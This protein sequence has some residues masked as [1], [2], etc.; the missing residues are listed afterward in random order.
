LVLKHLPKDEVGCCSLGAAE[1]Q[2]SAL[3]RCTVTS[4]NILE[5]TM[6]IA[7]YHWKVKE[8][9]EKNFLEGW[10]RRTEEIYQHCGSL[11]SRLHQAEDGTWVAYA[12]W[13]DRRTYDA[14]QSIPVTDAEARMMFRESIEESY[15]DIY[16]NVIDD[17]LKAEVFTKQKT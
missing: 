3:A 13:P 5:E 17:L 14:A 1:P 16:M 8:G 2:R 15:P 6:F 4:T 12:Q 9:H 7:L 10:H 11:G